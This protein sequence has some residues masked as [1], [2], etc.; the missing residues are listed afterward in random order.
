VA[1]GVIPVASLAFVAAELLT[2]PDAWRKLT[3]SSQTPEIA[4]HLS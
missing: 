3:V 1:Q 2:L 4:S